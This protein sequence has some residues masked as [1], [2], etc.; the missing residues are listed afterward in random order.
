METYNI[1]ERVRVGL[2]P[3]VK[4]FKSVGWLSLT[5]SKTGRAVH[6]ENTEDNELIYLKEV[7]L[8]GVLDP[9]SEERGVIMHSGEFEELIDWA[10]DFGELELE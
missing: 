7:Y 1:L 4:A 3:Y 9:T 2:R 6:F 5:N 8:E 10:R